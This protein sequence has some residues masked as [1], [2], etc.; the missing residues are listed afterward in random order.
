MTSQNVEDVRTSA[1]H[2][3]SIGDIIA[4]ANKLTA[5]QVE[6]IVT[7]LATAAAPEANWLLADFQVPRDGWKRFRSRLIIGCLYM[8]FR[9]M[10]RLPAQQLTPPA[11]LLERAGFS[12]QRRIETEWGLL[13]S[14]W[15][16]RS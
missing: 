3:R 5:E 10:T 12:L 1:L 15:W 4:E 9:V 16:Q 6:Q 8:F 11:P 14:D 7:R 2:D 13:H